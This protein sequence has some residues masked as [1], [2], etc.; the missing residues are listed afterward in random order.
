[1]KKLALNLKERVGRVIFRE[2][3][4]IVSDLEG[5]GLEAAALIVVTDQWC[6]LL[7]E[8]IFSGFIRDGNFLTSSASVG[9]SRLTLVHGVR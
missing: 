1:L 3:N 9:F 5:R 6:A 8:D 4:N 2:E 7:D